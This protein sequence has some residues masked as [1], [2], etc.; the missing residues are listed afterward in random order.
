[1]RHFKIEWGTRMSYI[2]NDCYFCKKNDKMGDLYTCGD[3]I[4][5]FI[6]K[7]ISYIYLKNIEI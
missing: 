6:K 5:K 7:I 2:N 1:M 4:C 3:I